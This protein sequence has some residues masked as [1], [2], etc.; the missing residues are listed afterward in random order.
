M[1]IL[2][3][4]MID[5]NKQ[6]PI[7][8]HFYTLQGEAAYAGH[9][10]YFIRLG[11]CNVGCVWCDVKESWE[12]EQHPLMTVAEMVALVKNAGAPI[13]VITGGEPTLH[14][15]EPITSAFHEIGVR[16]HMETAAT[17]PISGEWDWITISPKKFKAPLPENLALAHELKAIIYHKSDFAWVEQFV[18][19]L[20][21]KCRL[22]LQTEWSKRNE[23]TPL[24]IDYIKAHPTF[25]LSM[26]TH[27]YINIP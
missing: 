27:K 26:Q 20:N 23:M 4:V 9:A 22:Y 12:A 17:N 15:L 5:Q 16:C 21:S 18:P 19:M 6:Y 11:G 25:H 13:V 14:D 10:A 1:N 3:V 2:G 8:E 7:V 24:I